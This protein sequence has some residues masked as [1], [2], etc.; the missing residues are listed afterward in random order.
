[1]MRGLGR[2]ASAAS[3]AIVGGMNPSIVRE[4]ARAGSLRVTS[5]RHVRQSRG[6]EVECNRRYR[7]LGGQDPI[8]GRCPTMQCPG[9][10]DRQHQRHDKEHRL[11]PVNNSH[12]SKTRQVPIASQV[13]TP[14][15]TTS[16]PDNQSADNDQG[17]DHHWAAGR[18]RAVI[19]ASRCCHVVGRV[20]PTLGA[21]MRVAGA[22]V[23]SVGWDHGPALLPVRAIQTSCQQREFMF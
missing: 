11:E 1:M 7:Y 2:P 3:C 15:A 14:A 20:G 16:P 6:T 21:R 8:T 10:R 12:R 19:V 13:K 17:R 4:P 22:R 23:T 9:Q 18:R 5:R